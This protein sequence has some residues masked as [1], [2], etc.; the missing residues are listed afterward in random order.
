MKLRPHRAPLIIYSILFTIPFLFPVSAQSQQSITVSPQIIKLDLSVDAPEAV[1]TYTNN[2]N[3]TIE[4]TLTMQDVKELEDRG[5]PGILDPNQSQ[6][7][8]Y[9][10]SSWARFSNKNLV[11]SPKESKT[12][13]VFIDKERLSLGGHYATVLAELNQHDTQK[14]VKLRAILSSL[15]FVRSG[16]EYEQEKAIITGVDNDSKW[17]SFP[18]EISFMLQNSGNVDVT[19]YGLL[20]VTDPLG[21]E[22]VKNKINEDSLITLPGS[23]RRYNVNISRTAQTFMPGLYKVKVDIRYGKNNFTTASEASFLSLGFLNV[24]ILLVI[25][26]AAA[27]GIF[28]LRRLKMRRS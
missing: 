6:N 17:L 25:V 27:T 12:V 20:K 2:T 13:T 24:P 18:S 10:L 9:G 21:R 26:I 16:S 28:I 3:Q 1:Y 11:I 7:Y 19:P 22:V 15:L 23:T 14:K 5:I 4:L 8:P